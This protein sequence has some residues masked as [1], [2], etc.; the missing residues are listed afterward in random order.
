MRVIDC[1]RHLNAKQWEALGIRLQT[2]PAHVGLMNVAD[3]R[4]EVK[5]WYTRAER[6]FKSQRFYRELLR[7]LGGH[8][9]H[10]PP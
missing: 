8:E 5:G 3:V 6:G 9:Y 7:A 10:G 4:K 2:S 1:S